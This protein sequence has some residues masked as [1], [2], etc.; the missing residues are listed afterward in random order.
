M[1]IASDLEH[2]ATEARETALR[3]ERAQREHDD[4][5]ALLRA[6]EG[7]YG[8]QPSPSLWDSVEAARVRVDRAA[9]ALRV[10]APVAAAAEERRAAIEHAQRAEQARGELEARM[11]SLREELM[12]RHGEL[13]G[14][15]LVEPLRK[16]RDGLRLLFAGMNETHAEL[17][18][19]QAAR[20]Q[21]QSMANALN[22][23]VPTWEYLPEWGEFLVE[24]RTLAFEAGHNQKP[25][26]SFAMSGAFRVPP[27]KIDSARTIIVNARKV[28]S[29]MGSK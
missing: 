8:N 24:L 27:V 19:V 17:H 29:A 10:S 23:S 14:S 12:N 5:V 18:R 13:N 21:L 3:L 11:R 25:F 6:A 16:V 28:L 20:A 1:D 22:V 4:A 26:D 9:V 7:A 15:G 2:A